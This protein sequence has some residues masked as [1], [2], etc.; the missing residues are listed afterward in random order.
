MTKGYLPNDFFEV[1]IKVLL[2]GVDLAPDKFVRIEPLGPHDAE[3]VRYG[4]AP[5]RPVD[6]YTHQQ[7]RL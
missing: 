4:A 2:S 1:I 5:Y 3:R 6:T 7:F